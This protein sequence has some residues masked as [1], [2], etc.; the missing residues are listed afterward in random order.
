[1]KNYNTYFLVIVLSF[2]HILIFDF[3][4][5][6]NTFQKPISRNEAEQRALAM[7]DLQW[8]FSFNKNTNIDSNFSWGVTQPV[9]LQN[10]TYAQMTGIPYSWGG[11]DGLDSKSFMQPWDNFLDAIN[12]GAFAGNVNTQS[13]YGHVPGT[14]GLD[15]SGFVQATFNIKDHKQSTSTLLNYYFEQ[16]PM[17]QLKKMDVLIFPG[18]HAV[19]FDRWGT[20]NGIEGIYTY[21]STVDTFRGGIQGAKRYFRSINEINRGYIPARY[22]YLKDNVTT[23]YLPVDI[24]AKV[25]NVNY[26]VYLRQFNNLNSAILDVIL[27]DAIVYLVEYS[28]GWYKVSYN[29]KL[30]WIRSQFIGEL[31]TGKHVTVKDVYQLNIRSGQSTNHSI[32]GTISKNEY[33]RIIEYSNNGDWFKIKNGDVRGWSSARYLSYIY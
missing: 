17:S 13:G 25:A 2:L 14:A 33:A 30:G 27:K 29:G 4:S 32:V 21:E 23:Q 26:G 31:E 28:N 10:L 6:A 3:T 24:F 8:T 1:M 16:I 12:K 20:K 22:I 7:I 15:C 11:L 18:N 19:V 9:Q 5:H